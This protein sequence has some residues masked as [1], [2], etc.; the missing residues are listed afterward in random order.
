MRVRASA[1]L[2]D[3][4][5]F[6]KDFVAQN[7]FCKNGAVNKPQSK[8]NSWFV[9]AERKK[10]TKRSWGQL[11]MRHKVFLNELSLPFF[12]FSDEDACIRNW[13]D[14][15][16]SR[17]TSQFMYS[18]EVNFEIKRHFLKTLWPRTGSKK[19]VRL[20]NYNLN[21]TLDSWEKKERKTQEGLGGNYSWDTRSACTNYRFY[22]YRGRQ[23]HSLPLLL[24]LRNWTY[25]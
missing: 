7:W 23:Y 22:I 12:S 1:R 15:L 2:R 16:T 18:R 9:R 19:I 25:I 10:D 3:Q 21:Q 5:V 24:L 14:E 11:Y 17:K 4:T 13:M 6:S 8:P 20:I